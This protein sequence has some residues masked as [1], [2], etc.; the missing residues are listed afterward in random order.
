MPGSA[1]RTLWGVDPV[2]L[3]T[4]WYETIAAKEIELLKY[5]FINAEKGRDLTAERSAW[6]QQDGATVPRFSTGAGGG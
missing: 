4:D 6:V 1:L 5:P 2:R 3:T